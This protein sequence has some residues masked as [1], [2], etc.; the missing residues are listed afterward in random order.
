MIE[1]CRAIAVPSMS[2]KDKEIDRRYVIKNNNRDEL[3]GNIIHFK[4]WK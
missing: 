1:E 4:Q 2:A 3:S